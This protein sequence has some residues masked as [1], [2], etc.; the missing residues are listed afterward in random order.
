MNV[1]RLRCRSLSSTFFD[2]PQV[3]SEDHRVVLEAVEGVARKDVQFD[4]VRLMTSVVSLG[5]SELPGSIQP[6]LKA[7]GLDETSLCKR[8][9]LCYG[10]IS[11]WIPKKNLEAYLECVLLHNMDDFF[12]SEDPEVRVS[13]CFCL[14]LMARAVRA[15]GVTLPLKGEMLDVMMT[16]IRDQPSDG[17]SPSI[18]QQVLHTCFFLSQVRPL[19]K[20]KLM[21]V[22]WQSIL[23]VLTLPSVDSHGASLQE[24]YLC[25]AG[26]LLDLLEEILRQDC[27][28][29]TLLALLEPLQALCSSPC[30]VTRLRAMTMLTALLQ[31]CRTQL[32]RNVPIGRLL[33]FL[34]LRCRDPELAVMKEAVK[35]IQA[36]LDSWLCGED[37][38]VESMIQCIYERS[39]VSD[40]CSA[41][42]QVV[43]SCLHQPQKEILI[44]CLIQALRDSQASSAQLSCALLGSLLQAHHTE[45][46]AMHCCGSPASAAGSSTAGQDG[47]SAG[48]GRSLG[49]CSAIK[50]GSLSSSSC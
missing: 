26:C 40:T 24:L 3:V 38:E 2:N 30:G 7:H 29:D 11:L 1:F 46:T 23:E 8:I 20:R 9:V 12:T 4:T 36:L 32:E 25:N 45:H 31:F 16:F 14:S 48:T 28:P 39:S 17:S 50:V 19:F 35:G 37:G 22:A 47:R 33:A 44:E 10:F 21:D 41:L 18:C 27:N 43:S 49:T 13:V 42:T 5:F 34:V 6:K 15:M